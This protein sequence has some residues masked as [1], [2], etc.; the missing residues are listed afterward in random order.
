MLVRAARRKAIP[1]PRHSAIRLNTIPQRSDLPRLCQSSTTL[2][3]VNTTAQRRWATDTA[4]QRPELRRRR[5]S[6]DISNTNTR[7][8][9]ATALAYEDIPFESGFGVP[10]PSPL[11]SKN[12]GLPHSRLVPA[13]DLYGDAPTFKKLVTS[14]Q[15]IKSVGNGISGDVSEVLAV[16]H[17]CLAVGR[18][19]R[20]GVILHRI[21]WKTKM[22]DEETIDLNNQYLRASVE[23]ISTPPSEAARQAIH[24][25]F[26]LEIR[27]KQVP[28][29]AE[30][31][32]YMLK[33]SLHS[34]AEE[35]G[36]N[37]RRLVRRYMAMVPGDEVLEVF[38]TDLLTGAELNQINQICP[39]YNLADPLIDMD[40]EQPESPT[41]HYEASADLGKKRAIVGEK[42]AN[43]E[44]KPV[45]QK[46]LG[47]KSL[48]KALSLF[49]NIPS[50]GLSMGDKTLEEQRQIQTELEQGA[51][52]AALYRWRDEHE[53]ME[54]M[55][56]SSSLQTKS[57]GARMW[58]WQLIL[59]KTLKRELELVEVAEAIQIKTRK[60]EE[61]CLYG[62]FLRII[63]TDQLAALTIL[64]C[65]SQLGSSGADKG[66]GL[67]RL[68][69]KIGNAVEE[70][71]LFQAI[72]KA[73]RK[74]LW[75][76]SGALNI[77]NLK[78]LTRERGTGTAIRMV[79]SLSKESGKPSDLGWAAWP[80]N[81]KAKV[82]AY[83]LSALVDGAK[84]P[85][86]CKHKTTQVENVQLQ[87]AFTHSF[88]YRLGKK[89][90]IL[91]ANKALV[92]SLKREPVH[93]LLAKHLP[94]LVEP[95][96]W[97]MFDK[98]GFLAHPSKLMR[99]KQGD[100]DQRYYAEAA[101]G[102]GDMKEL[103]KGL[104][105]LGKTGWTINQPVFEVMLEA[106]NSGEAVANIPPE[107]PEIEI[108]EEPESTQDP[109]QR[110]KW[111]HEVK[112]IANHKTGLHSQRCF[113]NFQLEI[114]RALRNETFYFPH[115]VDFR[116]R[117]YPIPPYLNHMGAD[118]CRG[119]LRFAK[120]KE[121]GETGLKWLKIHLS[122]VFGYDKASL[123]EREEFADAHVAEIYD[124][125]SNP[126]G[127]DK[128]WLDA[129]DPWQC[130]AACMEI[131]SALDSPDPARYVSKLPVHQDGTCNGLQHYAALGGDL[132]GAKQVNL[133]PSDRP[134]DVYS[135]VAELVQK[136]ISK[137]AQN[138]NPPHAAQLDGKITRKTVKQTVMTN[139]YGV[140]YVGAKSQ[141]KKQLLASQPDL[142][143]DQ[144]SVD[145][146]AGYVASK[147]FKVLGSMFKGAH[148]IQFWFGECA[149]RI[150]T[151]L[152][153][154][155][156]SFIEAEL[157]NLNNQTPRG[158]IRLLEQL[159]TNCMFRSTVIWTTPLNMPVVQP[160]R[161]SKTK[162]V[163]TSMQ[164]ILL[165]NPHRTDPVQKRK[166]LQA[167][168]PNFVH[169]LDATHM[170]LSAI[171]CDRAGLSFAAVHDSFWT[172]A[173][174]V[175]IMNIALRDSFIK[176]HEEDVIARL[177]EEFVSRYQG[178]MYQAQVRINTEVA[179]KI[180]KWRKANPLPKKY[181]GGPRK[182][183]YLHELILER[184]RSRLLESDNPEE[185]KVGMEMV[186]PAS[187]F[188]K[189]S[190]H[191]D[192]VS[193]PLV[194]EVALGALSNG[195]TSIKEVGEEEEDLEQTHGEQIYD[196]QIY[197]EQTHDEQ[198]PDEHTPDEHI[199]DEQIHE[200][201]PEND[202]L[203]TEH[204][205]DEA[206]SGEQDPEST[207]SG[208]SPWKKIFMKQGNKKR[209]A[210]PVWLPL[211]FPPIPKKG[212][213]DVSQTKNSQY[214]FS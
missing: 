54:K 34:P 17:A 186:T 14:E 173:A 81:L 182:P 130:L 77:E 156:I 162:S 1:L 106:W 96:P 46:G 210:I 193:D 71:C 104:D 147:I 112:R 102:Q 209:I 82:G 63:A 59:T 140:T 25:W 142:G 107:N 208:P 183:G 121:L 95:D 161:S 65:M 122:N 116:G 128:W 45:I 180:T 18:I 132:W 90:G 187:I 115:N 3:C 134:A 80:L 33:A 136:D 114:A 44:V 212:G 129:E 152:T 62:P 149:G 24:K 88:H 126:M 196:D 5:N 20:A 141:V 47:L 41:E 16:F 179:E 39:R 19:E 86:I 174:D 2:Q 57:I 58:Q 198:T 84:V 36:G 93:G 68:V 83:L 72:D 143:T 100:K 103:C 201:D 203:L 85:V 148:D 159:N 188:A 137:D 177:R 76:K 30:T 37:R 73:R 206:D 38:A 214:F 154:E 145:S 8:S 200:S 91:S 205:S 15:K 164:N 135:A 197:V 124:S 207:N 69:M 165:M 157:P 29:T 74:N 133:V 160:Y 64:T 50:G 43:A 26:E 213:F 87:P 94:M 40:F 75:P 109:L 66:L 202:A 118:H 120:G 52:D 89:I 31:I 48:K 7:R 189:F 138:R 60:D 61:R 144:A 166:Q 158:K 139:V 191:G 184:E 78:K 42:P 35:T 56:I 32:A 131:K 49:S 27:L 110:R 9:M 67:T 28:F 175:P 194:A 199:P 170:L 21:L 185:V 13:P 163:L 190:K 119:L 192:L 11:Y 51:V 117:A 12:R 22:T 195:E 92:E 6:N 153:P 181:N 150:S 123:R 211:T 4:P 113:Q 171:E 172:H 176:L 97:T 155:Q 99:V 98:G 10:P 204:Q 70:E 168:P 178:S 79:T 55:G 151:S 111:L 108:P 146:L 105:V 101:I 127:G 23:H 125:A 167:F 53:S 169:S